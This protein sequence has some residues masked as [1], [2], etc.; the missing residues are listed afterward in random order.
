M[1]VKHKTTHLNFMELMNG[2]NTLV[3]VLKKN[4]GA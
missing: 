3:L 4:V 1:E 2:N